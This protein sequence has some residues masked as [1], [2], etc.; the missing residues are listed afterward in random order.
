MSNTLAT[1]DADRTFIF[2]KPASSMN[3][4][5]LNIPEKNSLNFYCDYQIYLCALE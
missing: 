4:N 5:V 3:E 1:T 2:N